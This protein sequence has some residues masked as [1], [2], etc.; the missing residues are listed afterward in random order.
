MLTLKP[1][2]SLIGFESVAFMGHVVW[3][4]ILQ[5]EDDKLEKIRYA[6]RPKTMKHVCAFSG[7]AE[8][9]KTLIPAF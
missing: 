5:M 4:G 3:K 8:Y 1:S 2:K 6:E 9:Y 7:L